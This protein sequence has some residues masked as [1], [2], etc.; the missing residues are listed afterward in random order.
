MVESTYPGKEKPYEHH[1]HARIRGGSVC[2]QDERALPV[3]SGS[4]LRQHWGATT[5]FSNRRGRR[6]RRG[7]GVRW[8]KCLGLLGELVLHH[9]LPLGL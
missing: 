1:E 8:L 3:C 4:K 6:G 5:Y 7:H 9:R 2:I